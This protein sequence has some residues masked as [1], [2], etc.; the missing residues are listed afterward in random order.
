MSE[1]VQTLRDLV[2]LFERQGTPYAVMGGIA[3]RIYAI[4]R[5]TFD[6]DVTLAIPR[7]R[8]PELYASLEELGLSVPEAYQSG[9]VD[10]VAGMPLVK[11]RLYL[12]GRGVDVDLFL[13]ESEYQR[14]LLARR[15]QAEVEGFWAW[16][17][18]PEDLV[19]LKLVAH[20]PRDLADIGD[21]LFVQGQLDEGY[22]RRWAAELGVLEG[23]E[24]VLSDT[25]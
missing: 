18:S 5:P 22:L 1:L 7:D 25:R 13:A 11:A 16:F 3:V 14:E 12:E 8:L 21:I 4:P 23:L 19:L 2:S 17:V 24:R 9:W 10:S 20:R 6:V 15:R